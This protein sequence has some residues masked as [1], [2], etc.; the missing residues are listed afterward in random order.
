MSAI[1]TVIYGTPMRAADFNALADAVRSSRPS[2]TVTQTPSGTLITEGGGGT[3]GLIKLP[4]LWAL[5]DGEEGVKHFVAEVVSGA[6]VGNTDV[7]FAV[8]VAPLEDPSVAKRSATLEFAEI[9]SDLWGA[10]GALTGAR[11]VAHGGNV[12]FTSGD[13][14]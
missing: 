9:A 11:F 10:F 6:T 7:I 5:D 3:D 4:N 1:P 13:V 12:R 14:P 8:E 2:G